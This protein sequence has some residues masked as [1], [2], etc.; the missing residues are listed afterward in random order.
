MRQGDTGTH[1]ATWPVDV[2]K[3]H[4]LTGTTSVRAG[5]H[6]PRIEENPMK[7][8]FVFSS[9]FLLASV[10]A[11]GCAIDGADPDPGQPE[12]AEA[13]RGPIG[14]AD[15]YGSCAGDGQDHC[16]SISDGNC[17]C[18]D[19][20]AD[21]G[22]CCEDKATT[23]DGCPDPDDPLVTYY[24]ESPAQCMAM[25]YMCPDD[26]TPFFGLCG[27][28]CI[29]EE[30]PPPQGCGGIAGL[31]CDE[32]EYCHYDTYQCGYADQMG[33]CKTRPEMCT[34]EYQPV[35][36][37]DSRTYSNACHAHS[38]GQSVFIDRACG[39][40]ETGCD[41]G[42]YCSDCWGSFQCIPDGAVC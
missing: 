18:D 26:E 33:E 10:A 34:E 30:P 2:G 31:T 4:T 37:C 42:Q 21:Y 1:H 9:L 28:G 32:G 6:R 40:L 3:Y 7:P 19:L 29:A 20:C 36:G 24:G 39:C 38:A 23:C 22:D 15:L 27:C 12:G 35:C 14:K 11:A 13:D 25:F 16:G 8:R 5:D 41:E 17:W